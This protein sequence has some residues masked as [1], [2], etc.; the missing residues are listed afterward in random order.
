M[1]LEAIK[2]SLVEALSR[3][4]ID[5]YE[6]YYNSKA[7]TSVDTLNGEINAFS[8][9]ERGGI[10]LRVLADGKM[11]YAATELMSEE[12]M[13][14][15]ARRAL[16]SAL[17]TEKLDTVGF[18]RGSPEYTP[19]AA[20]AAAPTATELREGALRLASLTYS[21]GERVGEGTAT[22]AFNYSFTVRLLNSHGLDLEYTAAVSAAYAEAVVETENEK[23]S[24]YSVK[25]LTPDR[26]SALQA[27][28]SEA[29]SRAERKLGAKIPPSG[30]YDLVIDASAM[31]QLLSTFSSSFSA[32]A[33]LEGMSR[34]GGRVGEKIAAD[35]ITLTDDPRREGSPMHIPFDAEGV[36][37]ARRAL[38]ERGVLRTLLHNRET[39]KR[40]N[41]DSTANASKASYSSPIGVRPYSLAIEPSETSR[42]E[43]FATAEGGIYITE[44][45]GLHAGA[46]PVTGD[47]S[48]ESEGF[49]IRD[50]KA[51]EPVKSFTVAG[52]FF[53]LLSEISAVASD[54]DIGVPTGS[55]G[56]GSPS[57]LVRNMSV[58]GE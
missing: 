21:A 37:T 15:L 43:L 39:A 32:K 46:N 12:E 55:V 49:I 51:A 47:F 3:L 8:S 10:C 9:G 5:E 18:F 7:E 16:E 33:A 28:A 25:M 24:D 56:F 40:M 36:A 19:V 4:G 52:N 30:R 1:Q 6:I 22:S 31:R 26:E 58:A 48:L 17:I 2:K 42:E 20:A 50:G 45:K 27:I 38:I 44:V 57:V 53:T 23:I 35:C 14:S 54:L 34:L 41:T 13:E 11:G 29:V